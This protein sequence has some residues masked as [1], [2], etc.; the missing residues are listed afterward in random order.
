MQLAKE[1]SSITTRY[2]EGGKGGDDGLIDDSGSTDK[3]DMNVLREVS[4]GS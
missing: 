1:R 2:T 3:D 4:V